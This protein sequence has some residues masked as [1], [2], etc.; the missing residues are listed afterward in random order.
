MPKLLIVGRGVLPLM[1]AL[2][3]EKRGYEPVVL[4]EELPVMC[5]SILG[6]LPG[7]PLNYFLDNVGFPLEDP[8]FYHSL[9]PSMIFLGEKWQ[10]LGV[11]E[12]RSGFSDLE[13]TR[14]MPGFPTFQE[15]LIPELFSGM[16]QEMARFQFPPSFTTKMFA[17]WHRYRFR[18]H[19][20][21]LKKLLSSHPS[22]LREWLLFLEALKPFLGLSADSRSSVYSVRSLVAL[23]NGWTSAPNNPLLYREVH[24]VASKNLK[25]AI[26]VWEGSPFLVR[27]EGRR[28]G[29]FIESQ[30][31]GER[32]DLLL[33]LSSELEV[34]SGMD[35][36]EWTVSE[37]SIPDVWPLQ[38]LIPER[39]GMPSVLFQGNL[40]EDKEILYRITVRSTGEGN[41]FQA[42]LQV[43]DPL[44]LK[45][46]PPSP[47]PQAMKRPDPILQYSKEVLKSGWRI[48]EPYL[49]TM[50]PIQRLMDPTRLP[51]LSDDWIR[52]LFYVLKFR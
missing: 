27:M 42:P 40:A 14:W 51:F 21:G 24:K 49:M 1:A 44:L 18:R 7:L 34:P 25:K 9:S 4:H 11:P 16:K 38:F 30:G 50:G 33:D 5:S 52:Q 31:K 43:L 17:W 36:W 29:I 20:L 8:R 15:S 23:L 26:R 6:G 47:L 3:A 2:L 41:S 39:G 28:K 19:E 37:S 22:S 48:R 45:A 13:R 32:F 35:R 46:L 10:L 12:L